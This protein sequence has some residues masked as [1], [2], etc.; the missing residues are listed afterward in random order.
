MEQR[1]RLFFENQNYTVLSYLK[2]VNNYVAITTDY[3]ID[4]ASLLK[5]LDPY[6]KFSDTILLIVVFEQKS[7]T[8]SFPWNL[9]E[10]GV[11]DIV[12]V[13]KMDQILE[14]VQTHFNRYIAI[15]RLIKNEDLK[16]ANTPQQSFTTSMN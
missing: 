4:R 2:E 11:S 13:D 7:V 1:I 15:N 6:R 3:P 12:F 9:T 8:L 5:A 10:F 16:K 14:H